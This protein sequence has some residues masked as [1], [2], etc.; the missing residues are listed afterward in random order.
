MKVLGIILMVVGV[1]VFAFSVSDWLKFIEAKAVV[2][3]DVMI[4]I[5]ELKLRTLMDSFVISIGIIVSGFLVFMI[6]T[7]LSQ[8]KKSADI[9]HQQLL[10]VR[11]GKTVEE[12][13]AITNEEHLGVAFK[14]GKFLASIINK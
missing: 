1:L 6:R 14:F 10:L 4:L 8:R 12:A 9:K 11:S 7:I 3:R 2:E 13:Q 5:Y